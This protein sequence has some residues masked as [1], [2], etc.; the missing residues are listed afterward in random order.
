MQTVPPYITW[1]LHVLRVRTGKVTDLTRDPHN[2]FDPAWSPDGKRIVFCQR[3]GEPCG[4]PV[5]VG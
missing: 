2:E 4:L 3:C 5:A 1:D